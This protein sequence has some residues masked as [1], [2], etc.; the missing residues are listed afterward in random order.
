MNKY[1]VKEHD[2]TKHEIEADQ[3][4]LENGRL[5]FFK[6]GDLIASFPSSATFVKL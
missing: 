6:A 4:K 3:M 1:F 5:L 2:G